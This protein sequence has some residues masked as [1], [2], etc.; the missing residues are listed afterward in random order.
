VALGGGDE[1]SRPNLP[2][3]EATDANPVSR[4]SRPGVGAN[5]RP[6]ILNAALEAIR[7]PPP[8]SNGTQLEHNNI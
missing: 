7:V 5:Q 6:V 8:P 2:N 1:S 4:A 3:L